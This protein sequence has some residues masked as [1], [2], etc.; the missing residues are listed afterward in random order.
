MSAAATGNG[1][2][3]QRHEQKG[4]RRR[5]DEPIARCEPAAVGAGYGL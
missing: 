4:D 2:G 3:A 1:S 5:I